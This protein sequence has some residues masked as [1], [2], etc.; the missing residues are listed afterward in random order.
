M[1][2]IIRDQKQ[3]DDYCDAL[4]RLTSSDQSDKQ[5]EIE[6]LSLL[7]GNYNERAMEKYQFSMD[8]VE[9][10][11]DLL[12]ENQLTQIAL[13]KS[14]NTSPQLINDVLKYRREITKKLSLKL[15]QEFGVSHLAFLQPY[16]LKK[17][18]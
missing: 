5:D 8:P 16:N 9:L 18:G 17:A 15:A 2:T 14:I 11:K 4:E 12:E 6:L 13:A 1:Y 7:I 10:L 3:Y